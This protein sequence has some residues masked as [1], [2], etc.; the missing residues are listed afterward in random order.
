LNYTTNFEADLV[1]HDVTELHTE[2]LSYCQHYTF[3][4]TGSAFSLA[5]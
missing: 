2:E 1:S 4:S 3:P 5:S